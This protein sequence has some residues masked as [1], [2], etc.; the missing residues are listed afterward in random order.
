MADFSPDPATGLEAD[1]A[2]KAGT[3]AALKQ[4]SFYNIITARFA[5]GSKLQLFNGTGAVVEIPMPAGTLQGGT[6]RFPA[7]SGTATANQAC[8]VDSGTWFGRIVN[9][10]RYLD[11]ISTPRV[12]RTAPAAIRVG[13]GSTNAG[14]VEFPSGTS[15]VAVAE[16]VVTLPPLSDFGGSTGTGTSGGPCPLTIINAPATIPVNQTLSYTLSL[17]SGSATS[18]QTWLIAET[19]TG[20]ETGEGA[21]GQNDSIGGGPSGAYTK[22]I[23]N[24]APGKY[25]IWGKANDGGACQNSWAT[26]PIELTASTD[27]GTPSGTLPEF[28][29]SIPDAGTDWSWTTSSSWSTGVNYRVRGSFIIESNA[30]QFGPYDI[31]DN[32]DKIQR[33]GLGAPAG[34]G[35]VGSFRIELDLPYREDIPNHSENKSFPSAIMGQ[36]GG[37][38]DT[39]PDSGT[40]WDNIPCQVKNVNT[41]WVGSKSRTFNNTNFEGWAI[42]DCRTSASSQQ[43][44]GNKDPKPTVS[45]EFIIALQHFGGYGVIATSGDSRYRGTVTIDGIKWRTLLQYGAETVLIKLAPDNGVAPLHIN[46]GAIIKWGRTTRYQDLP[47]GAGP[48]YVGS[49]SSF[50]MNPDHY[51]IS[52][53]PGLETVNGKITGEWRSAYL[54]INRDEF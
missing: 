50:I 23:S 31:P 5:N 35:Q 25:K 7:F 20:G 24:I 1:A 42:I 28:T 51:F 38:G 43:T 33:I 13:G 54:R 29:K 22:N 4:G 21:I 44:F 11:S 14:V 27:P 30:W 40:W 47:N 49:P 34:N 6:L 36:G 18:W 53:N 48:I 37:W 8:D 15:T 41:G 12:G 45:L 46:M 10:T 39:I 52:A 32:D 9:G 3:T 17:T 16:T 2:A 19:A 26:K